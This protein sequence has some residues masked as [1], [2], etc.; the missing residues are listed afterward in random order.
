MERP[1]GPTVLQEMSELKRAT[2]GAIENKRIELVACLVSSALTD[3]DLSQRFET[4]ARMEFLQSAQY[5]LAYLAEAIV[6]SDV[7]LFVDYIA[8]AKS[9]LVSRGRVANDLRIRLE[10]VRDL[11]LRQLPEPEGRLASGYIDQGLNQFPKLSNE[12]PTFMAGEDII[13]QLAVEYLTAVLRL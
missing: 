12:I 9:V 7:S 5:D 2:Y 8:W 13:P 10:L 1:P 3:P 6:A 4:E 11:L